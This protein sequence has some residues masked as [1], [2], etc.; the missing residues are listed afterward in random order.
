MWGLNEDEAIEL[1]LKESLICPW[2]GS[3][4][5]A[6]RLAEVLFAET[7]QKMDR[8]E[9]SNTSKHGQFGPVLVLNGIDGL[10]ELLANW[11]G[12]VVTDFVDGAEPGSIVDGV[13]HEDA[14]AL[15]FADSTFAAVIHSETLEHIP[16]LDK[17]L[18][19]IARVLQPGGV[20]IFTIPMKPGT[21]RTES[22]MVRGTDGEWIDRLKP[23]LHH[24]GG[25]WGWPVQ[26][27]FGEDFADSLRARGWEVKVDRRDS[28]ELAVYGKSCVCEVFVARRH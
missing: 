19:E 1:R 3:K 27:E 14:Q 23:R 24:P 26:T 17:A 5:R 9:R 28:G 16:D 8:H 7:G 2:C 21:K 25:T 12:A 4:H 10:D 22:R 20:Q 15:T 6:R 18:S 13:R 11:P